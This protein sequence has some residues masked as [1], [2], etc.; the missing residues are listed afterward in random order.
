MDVMV[1]I[2]FMKIRIGFTGG[3]M[4]VWYWTIGFIKGVEYFFTVSAD[5]GCQK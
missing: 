4:L 1:W 3:I 2:R 5:M